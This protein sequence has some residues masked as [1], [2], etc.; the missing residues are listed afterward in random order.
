MN[1]KKRRLMIW[2]SM[3]IA[4]VF[5]IMTIKSGSAVLFFD[6]VAR[7]AAGNYVA[8]VLWFNFVAGFFYIIAG[9]GL[10]IKQAWAAKLAVIIAMLTVLTFAAFGIYILMGGS[11]EMRTVIAM[12][13]RSVIWIIIAFVATSYNKQAV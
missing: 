1:S 12:I 2:P 10:W 11:Y 5:G 9:I 7:Q 6:G 3:I 4:I 13:L 8:F